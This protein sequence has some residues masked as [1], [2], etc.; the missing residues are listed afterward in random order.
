MFSILLCLFCFSIRAVWRGD[1]GILRPGG[2]VSGDSILDADVSG[3]IM[4]EA[5]DYI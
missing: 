1:P 3:A 2:D 5:G 4:L